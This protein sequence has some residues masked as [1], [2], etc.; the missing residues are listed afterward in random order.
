V[1]KKKKVSC[2]EKCFSSHCDGTTEGDPQ[3]GAAMDRMIRL[4]GKSGGGD[5]GNNGKGV[6]CEVCAC[7]GIVVRVY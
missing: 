2:F 1:R 4:V 3:T 5:S 6:G 7:V